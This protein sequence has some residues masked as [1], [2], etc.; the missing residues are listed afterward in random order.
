MTWATFETAA[1]DLAEAGRRLMFR[2]E[3]GEVFL[4]TVRDDQLPRI[5]PIWVEILDGHLLAF[6]HTDPKS[7]DLEHDG[8]YAMHIHIDPAA[9]SEFSIRG[10]AWAVTDPERRQAAAARWPFT[11]DEG[12]VLFEFDIEVAVLGVRPDEN[13]WPPV[14]SSWRAGV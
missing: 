13:A 2:G 4:V 5:H 6:L 1:P 9:P 14:Y 8:R 3:T 12:Y 10:R 7:R 11:V